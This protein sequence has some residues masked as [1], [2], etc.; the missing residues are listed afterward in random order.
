M[1][2]G[3]KSNDANLEFE[4][5]KLLFDYTKFH[6]GL[7]TT[8]AT[9][10]GA[11]FAAGDKVPLRFQPVLL[12]CSAISVCIAGAAGGIIASSIPAFDS[13]SKFW[14]SPIGPLWFKGMKAK[15]WTHIE[16]I[17]FWIAIGLAIGSVLA[18]Y[19]FEKPQHG[20]GYS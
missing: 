1:D 15:C 7:Y 11:L 10:F 9:I 12:L 2:I 14:D 4:Q 19:A 8:I 6:I 18:P 17:A 16:H 5:L 13:Y 20:L 3:E